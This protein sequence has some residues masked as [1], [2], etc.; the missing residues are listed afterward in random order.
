MPQ[1]PR[2]G[3]EQKLI[4]AGISKSSGKAYKAFWAC[5][6]RECKPEPIPQDETFYTKPPAPKPL[7]TNGNTSHAM[8]RLSYR[9]DLMVALINKATEVNTEN[10]KKVFDS[11]W[12]KVENL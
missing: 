9:K 7:E 11:L 2:C 4:P 8:M 6:D 3:Q 12:D 10:I 1:C 5:P